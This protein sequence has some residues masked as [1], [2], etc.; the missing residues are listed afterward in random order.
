MLGTAAKDTPCI[1]LYE[2]S[3]HCVNVVDGCVNRLSYTAMY[4]LE[5]NTN[6]YRRAPVFS[7]SV[8]AVRKKIGKLNK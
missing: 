7:D 1:S 8:P 6:Q 4:Y 5:A 2:G 3:V